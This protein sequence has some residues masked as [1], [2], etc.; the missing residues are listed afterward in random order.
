MHIASPITYPHS[1]QANYKDQ[2]VWVWSINLEGPKCW[3]SPMIPTCQLAGN[4]IT[5]PTLNLAWVLR[6]WEKGRRLY[7]RIWRYGSVFHNKQQGGAHFHLPFSGHCCSCA[8]FGG[9]PSHVPLG[10][11][12]RGPCGQGSNGPIKN[13]ECPY[14]KAP[15]VLSSSL[16]RYVRNLFW[17]RVLSPSYNS[18]GHLWFEKGKHLLSVPTHGARNSKS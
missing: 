9:V 17:V 18:C 4:S 12:W 2:G 10:T 16:T 7:F 5:N 1:R 11:L 3:L 8:L 15:V 13:K 6:T 14:P